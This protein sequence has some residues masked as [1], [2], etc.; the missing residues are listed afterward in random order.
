MRGQLG[1]GMGSVIFW[2]HVL[3]IHNVLHVC[4]WIMYAMPPL[5][6]MT[7]HE[8][9]VQDNIQSSSIYGCQVWSQRDGAIQ[10]RLRKKTMT[11]KSVNFSNQKTST[12]LLTQLIKTYNTWLLW[13]LI[14]NCWETTSKVSP[15]FHLWYE[16]LESPDGKVQNETL[17]IKENY[18][19]RALRI[20]EVI[21]P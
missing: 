8:K 20:T 17:L 5:P 11:S 1:Q 16:D 2:Q 14:W 9:S 21:N 7:V 6:G 12:V 15:S 4:T 18:Y 10:T 3:L 19:M 13:V